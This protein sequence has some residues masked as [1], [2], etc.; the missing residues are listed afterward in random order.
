MQY[1]WAYSAVLF[2]L[3]NGMIFR[4]KVLGIKCIFYTTI[5]SWTQKWRPHPTLTDIRYT[6]VSVVGCD[7]IEERD[8]KSDEIAGNSRFSTRREDDTNLKQE[9]RRSVGAS[10]GRRHI[11]H[12]PVGVGDEVKELQER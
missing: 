6:S 9:M 2:I 3:I 4:R 11:A 10:R 5:E 7:V 12:V 8:V 1:A